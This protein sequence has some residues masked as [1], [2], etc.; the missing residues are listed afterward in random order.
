VPVFVNQH[1]CLCRP[2]ANAAEHFFLGYTLHSDIG[3]GQFESIQ[4]GGTKQGLGLQEVKDV[5]VSLPPKREQIE[6]HNHLDH[7]VDKIEKARPQRR[8]NSP[9][10]RIPHPP[11]RRR[12]DREARRTGGGGES[13]GGERGARA[14]R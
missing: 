9:C 10:V 6:I 7:V 4:Y 14:A 12:G 5:T 1:V 13:A 2:R 3:Q 8:A 11:D